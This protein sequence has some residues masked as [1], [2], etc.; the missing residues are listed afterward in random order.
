MDP[1]GC[2]RH[3]RKPSLFVAV[4][5]DG[6]AG[7]WMLDGVDEVKGEMEREAGWAKLQSRALASVVVAC[8]EVKGMKA[9]IIYK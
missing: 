3:N 7:G 1:Q 6:S 5:S 4:V 9:E 2:G 8:K